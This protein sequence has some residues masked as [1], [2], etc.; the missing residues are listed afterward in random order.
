VERATVAAI[1]FVAWQAFEYLV[2]QRSI[3]RRSIHLGPFVTLFAGLAGLELY[4]L[5]GGLLA[6]VLAAAVVATADELLP[7]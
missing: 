4:G 1:A 3:E 6:V 7:A 2:V 5:G